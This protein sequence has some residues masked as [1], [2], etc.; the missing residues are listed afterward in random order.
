M[1]PGICTFAPEM[2]YLQSYKRLNALI[3]NESFE[4]LIS[5]GLRMALSG[6][7][8]VI[9]GLATGRVVDAIWITLTAEAVSWVEMKGSFAWR[10]RTLLAGAF[11]GI[12]FSILGTVTGFNVWL[13]VVGMFVVGYLA[14]LLKNLGDRAS[15]LAICVYLMFIICNAFPATEYTEVRH[16]LALVAIGAAWPVLVG[17]FTSLLMPAE[18]PFRRQIALIWRAISDLVETVSR[19]AVSRDGQGS[20]DEVIRKENQVRT[21]IDNSYQFYG[22][23]AHQVKKKNDPQYQLVLLRKVAGL[24]A[25]NVVAME[26]EIKHIAVPELDETL[27]IKAATLFSA[28]KE[29][30]TRISIFVISLKPEEKLL[31]VSH[32]N[33]V[34]KLTALIRQYPMMADQRQVNAIKRILHLTDRTVKLMESAIERIEQMGADKPVFR[35]YSFAKTL[36]ILKPRY[37]ISSLRVLFNFSSLTTRYALRSAIA[38]TVALFIYKWFRIDH[39]YWLPF[40]VMIVI[41][42]YFGATFQKALDRVIGTVLGGLAGSLLLHLPAGSHVKEAI[43]F[44]TFILMVY[45][46]RKK[47]SVAVFV[48]TL[49]LVLLFNLESA[50]NNWIMVT[51]ALCTIGGAA[52]AVV[53]G[54][55]LLPTWDKKWLPAH[56]AEAIKSNYDYFIATFFAEKRNVNWT[57]EK[58]VAESGNSNVFDSFN[59][60]M[61]E[62]G[63]EKSEVYYDLIT[64]NVRITRNLNNIHLEQD[65]KRIQ[66]N[67]PPTIAQQNRINE[68]LDCFRGVLG[69]LPNLDPDIPVEKGEI[70][71]QFLS[72]FQLNNAQMISLEKLVIELK[73]MREDMGKIDRLS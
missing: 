28:M 50:Y 3:Q 48:I 60:Y 20:M 1:Q 23:M 45:F 55:A 52:L 11:L 34:K 19:S 9:W 18:Q 12:A 22:R 17:I 29:A 57:R 67:M 15:G 26:E 7:L 44:L 14:T 8:P 13:S 21:A 53:S 68:C 33:R 71:E 69:K 40:S 54:F 5:W 37:F 51:R 39:G 42:P 24:V 25:V 63:K 16:R 49:N 73:T 41:Q 56:L 70:N 43:L 38:A 59:R 47:Y 61:E 31:A 65:E 10:V 58:R 4:P 32:I 2:S 36:F 27:R 46:L 62:P 72:P 35:S 64:Y 66:E 30:V 6:T